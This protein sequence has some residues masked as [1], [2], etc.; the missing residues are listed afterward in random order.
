MTELTDLTHCPN[1]NSHKIGKYCSNCGQKIYQKRFTLKG[2]FEVVG[3][4]LNFEKGFFHT[5]VWLFYNPGT[6]VNDYLKGKT[7]SY[8]NPLNYILIIAGIYAFL[9]LSL[10]IL[11]KSI[12]TTNQIIG[13][14]SL[15]VSPHALEMQKR[16]V[17]YIKNYVN[18]IPI[19][20]VPFAAIFSKWYYGRQNL[21]YGEHLILN[22]FLFAQT[23]L[24][25]VVVSPFVMAF[26]GLLEN[27]PII[28]LGYTLI[29]FAYA[30]FRIFKQSLY[31]AV[32]GSV[33]IYFG[34]FLFFMF[35]IL[36]MV[37]LI[38]LIL[39]LLGFNLAD[40]MK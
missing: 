20:M 37:F 38:L 18:F 11:D 17:E 9:V 10:G 31:K 15:P 40:M 5:L 13:G 25:S 14:D 35:F 26:P 39:K 29:Y 36:T 2:F 1:C 27:F 24:I 21:F 30:F 33:V 19:L 6:M 23:I 22:T 34:G 32:F 7:K 8:I 12:Q 16:A 28:S 3:N 4:A